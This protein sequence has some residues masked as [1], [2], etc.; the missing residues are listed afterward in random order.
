[1]TATLSARALT[2]L[3]YPSSIQYLGNAIFLNS[4]QVTRGCTGIEGIVPL[5]VFLIVIPGIGRARKFIA[6]VSAGSVMYLANIFRIVLELAMYSNGVVSWSVVH[7]D[8]GFV[9]S[10]ASVVM[11][12][13]LAT[14]IIAPEG[15]QDFV[16][17][18]LRTVR[19]KRI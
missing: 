7:D 18:L 11:I 1:L 8:F 16:K 14:R 12:L 15:A 3:G 17:T 13:F 9:F 19:A 2:S 4:F 6:V 5:A 10:V